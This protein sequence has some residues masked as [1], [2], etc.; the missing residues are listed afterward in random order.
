MVSCLS[1]AFFQNLNS[2]FF[3]TKCL[4]VF[5]ATIELSGNLGGLQLIMNDGKLFMKDLLNVEMLII[6]D[7]Q[8]HIESRSSVLQ[9]VIGCLEDI[10][11]DV[12]I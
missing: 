1:Y 7:H 11:Y 2:N 8:L 6:C 9:I 12:S 5:T 3:P 10:N 4:I